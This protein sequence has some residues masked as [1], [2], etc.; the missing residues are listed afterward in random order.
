[1]GT[2]PIFVPKPPDMGT[3]RPLF[4]F[5]VQLPDTQNPL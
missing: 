5:L 3:N 1:L 2:K 4:D